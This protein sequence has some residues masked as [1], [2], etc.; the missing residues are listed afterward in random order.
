MPSPGSSRML[1]CTSSG[2]IAARPRRGRGRCAT[3]RSPGCRRPCR[4]S[5]T[6]ARR[7]ASRRRSA[8]LSAQSFTVSGSVQT[9]GTGGAA[10]VAAAHSDRRRARRRGHARHPRASGTPAGRGT[11]GRGERHV[12]RARSQ[13]PPAGRARFPAFLLRRAAGRGAQHQLKAPAADRRGE[14]RVVGELRQL[15]RERRLV[16][17]ERALH[18]QVHNRRRG[19]SARRGARA[20]RRRRPCA[21]G[22]MPSRC[23]RSRRAPPAGPAPATPTLRATAHG[24]SEMNMPDWIVAVVAWRCRHG[25]R[26]GD[27]RGPLQELP[28]E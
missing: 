2:G 9:N 10:A 13:S 18:R 14:R 17:V 26:G 8:A 11:R 27:H 3:C 20:W 16:T 7:R 6:S 5:D 4:R 28:R 22:R 21:P 19:S 24:G 25:E 12:S 15:R 23:R 1:S